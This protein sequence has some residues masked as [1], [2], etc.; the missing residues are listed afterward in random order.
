MCILRALAR[1]SSFLSCKLR[2]LTV[3]VFVSKKKKKRHDGC[4]W[5]AQVTTVV[6]E[7]VRRWVSPTSIFYD[8]LVHVTCM[9]PQ[10]CIMAL[11]LRDAF[12]AVL[13]LRGGAIVHDHVS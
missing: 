5:L 4:P 11:D 12:H 3:I 7:N 2:G 8:L 10:F 9:G 6:L 1:Q 13:E